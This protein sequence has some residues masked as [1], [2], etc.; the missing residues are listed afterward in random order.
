M[1]RFILGLAIAAIAASAVAANAAPPQVI[2][3]P[4]TGAPASYAV[5]PEF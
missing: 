3:G 2:L 5:L 4:G 1:K